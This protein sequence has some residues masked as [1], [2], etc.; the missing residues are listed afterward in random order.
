[1]SKILM[2]KEFTALRPVDAA[3]H[4]A[5][6]KLAHDDLVTVEIRKSRNLQHHR[7]FWA[8]CSLVADNV[9]GVTAEQVA[10]VLKLKTGHCDPVKTADGT[11]HMIPKSI[12]FAAM[13][14][15]EFS[16]FYD[17]VVE[18]VQRDWLPGVKQAD[19]R[20]ELEEMTGLA[21]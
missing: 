19:L 3:G 15:T 18:V 14:Q 1:M 21:A 17:R 9:T 12:S 10:G 13:D 11:I 6:A 16:A 20:R 5:M 2:R 7:L 4:Q 8:L